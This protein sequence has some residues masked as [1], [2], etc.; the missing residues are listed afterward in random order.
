MIR[1]VLYN[2]Y[3]YLTDLIKPAQSSSN[4]IYEQQ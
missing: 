1:G 4:F 2:L 3:L